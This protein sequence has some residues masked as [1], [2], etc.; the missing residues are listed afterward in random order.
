MINDIITGLR[1]VTQQPTDAKLYAVSESVLD[2]LG[3][4]NNLAYT[5]FKG[6]RVYCANER[7]LWEWREPDTPGE[8]GKLPSHFTYP[9]GLIVNGIDYGNKDYNFF[10]VLQA[11]DI[12]EYDAANVGEATEIYKDKTES[13][14]VITFN[15]RTLEKENVGTGQELINEIVVEGD[16]VKVK[17]NTLGT[18]N[19]N[20]YVNEDGTVMVDTPVSSSN[21]SFYVDVN[22]TADTETGSLAFPFKTLNKALDTFIGTGTWYNPQYKGYKITLLSACSLLES[23]GVDYNGYVGLDVNNL[24]IEGNGFYL[25]L[26]ANPSPDYYPISTRRMVTNM[27]KTA[28]VM[29]YAITMLFDNVVFQRTGTNAIVDYLA[30]SFPTATLVGAF[31]PQQT[32]VYLKMENCVLTN[33]T[34]RL[35][36]PNWNTVP[37]PNDSGNPL[38]MFGVPVYASDVEPV[39]VPMV[40]AEGRNWNKEGNMQLKNTN[41][42]NLSGPGWYF[43]NTSYQ[44]Y[45][46]YNIFQMANYFR[47]YDSEVDD[48]YSPRT[49]YSLIVLEDVNYCRMIDPIFNNTIP[50]MI[51]TESSP[52]N[53]QIGGMESIIKLINSRFYIDGGN[54]EEGVENF[55]QLDGDSSIEFKDFNDFFVNCND[56]HG[57]FQ[58]LAP[59][60]VTPKSVYIENS[61]IDEV[62][63][64]E[65]GVD[66]SYIIEVVG[67]RNT[68]NNAPH[69]IYQSHVDDATAKAAGLIKNNMYYN[70][71]VNALVK[72]L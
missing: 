1:T 54:S 13:G 60:P 38:L 65:T 43:K 69:S 58:V 37:N 45:G 59:L 23:A 71:T 28:N 14:G 21:L 9:A 35:P 70:T 22:S 12:A 53:R 32:D 3:P 68:I 11:S 17:G 2:S 5:Y 46:S 25:G 56:V 20:I 50:S 41:Y 44:D 7:T 4:G 61:K 47:Y 49:G 66:K 39:G 19:L 63:V 6:M 51:T 36:N 52:R 57:F 64:D 33:D 40:K 34:S 31:P 72:I 26:Y 8:V 16:V 18:T 27:P 10:Q 67:Y 48:F 62:I 30:Y 24:W 15:F 29:D 42:R 55:C